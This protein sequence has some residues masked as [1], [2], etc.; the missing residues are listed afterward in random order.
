MSI[1][2]LTAMKKYPKSIDY[3]LATMLLSS[4]LKAIMG[5][6]SYQKEA[7]KELVNQMLNNLHWLSDD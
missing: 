4:N 1:D 6:A 7:A 3:R 5:L 2:L